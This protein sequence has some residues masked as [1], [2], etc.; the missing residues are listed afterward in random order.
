MTHLSASP[1][2]A[3]RRPGRSIARGKVTPPLSGAIANSAAATSLSQLE[4]VQ[5]FPKLPAARKPNQILS[6]SVTTSLC[7]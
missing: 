3:P 1:P 7:R 2:H 5:S 6:L 4:R